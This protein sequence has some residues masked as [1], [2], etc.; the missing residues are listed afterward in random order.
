MKI[1]EIAKAASV[2][3]ETIRY[4]EKYGLIPKSPRTDSGYRNFPSEVVEDI[5]FI[6]RTQSLGF[7]LEEIKKLLAVSR[8][9]E[10][11]PE[12]MYHFTM[13]KAQEIETKIEELKNMKNLLE[14]LAEKCPRSKV[15]KGE[16][17]IIQTFRGVN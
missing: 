15:A 6:K 7:S 9:T 16:C 4:Y 5:H 11:Q 12:E 10:F 3:I 13:N 17:P 14:N 1:G 2:N 8:N